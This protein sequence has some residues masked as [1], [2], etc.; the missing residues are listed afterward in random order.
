MR[1]L[2]LI[3]GLLLP[4]TLLVGSASSAETKLAAS[5][6]SYDGKDFVRTE[7]TLMQG[8]QS[9]VGTKLEHD[10]PAYKALSEKHSYTGPATVF[11]QNYEAN[12]APLI[13]ADGKLTGALFVGVPK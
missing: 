7:T 1:R 8:G 6:F 13:G 5:I 9:A 3:L 2:F 12:Y 11:G 4:V 10:S